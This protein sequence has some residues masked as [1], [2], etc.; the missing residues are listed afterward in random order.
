MRSE[1][2]RRQGV[3]LTAAA[4]LLAACG[5]PKLLEPARLFTCDAKAAGTEPAAAPPPPAALSDIASAVPPVGGPSA[6][7][8]EARRLVDGERWPQAEALLRR[9]ARGESGDDRTMRQRAEHDL[10]VTLYYEDK[11]E[12]SLV[13]FLSI[14]AN[15]DHEK[16]AEAAAWL[17]RLAQKGPPYLDRA[18]RALATYPLATPRDLPDNARWQAWWGMLHIVGRYYYRTGNYDEALRI[19]ARVPP[20]ADA[21]DLSRE[22]VAVICARPG[23]PASCGVPH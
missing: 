2:G 4:L 1:V 18:A 13:I 5:D 20:R 3:A 22:C 8:S 17:F 6:D 21:Y 14:A 7:A 19:F 16:H 12:E 11:L 23:A 10:A 15:P 9:V